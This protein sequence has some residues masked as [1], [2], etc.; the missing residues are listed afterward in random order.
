MLKDVADNLAKTYGGRSFE[1]C[2]LIS[3]ITDNRTGKM[4][5]NSSTADQTNSLLV[6]NFP[7]IDAEVRFACREYACTIEDILSRRTRLAFL[8]RDAAL[9]AIPKV[10]EIMADELGWSETVKKEQVVAA[11]EYIS[12]YAGRTID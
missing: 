7:Y 5:L 6:Q 8:N 11:H 1:V 3:S 9:S 4:I 12:S 10:A 2:E